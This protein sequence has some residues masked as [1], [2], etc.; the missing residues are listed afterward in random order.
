MGYSLDS[1]FSVFYIF[2]HA[3]AAERVSD[4]TQL[5]SQRELFH[6]WKYPVKG[7]YQAMII[8]ETQIK[9][10]AQGHLIILK[11]GTRTLTG[12]PQGIHEQSGL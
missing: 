8:S 4:D 10:L 2:F 11:R 3:V 12:C 1:L 7:D 6:G 9:Q 5:V